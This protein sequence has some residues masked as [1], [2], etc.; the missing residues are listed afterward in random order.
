MSMIEGMDDFAQARVVEGMFTEAERERAKTVEAILRYDMIR[1]NH[2]SK[3][4][5][6][7]KIKNL[8]EL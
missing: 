5:T 3:E 1:T 6:I 8:I 4:V 7:Q 2:E